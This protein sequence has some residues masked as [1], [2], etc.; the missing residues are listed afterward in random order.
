MHAG[1]LERVN[2]TGHRSTGVEA[3]TSGDRWDSEKGSETDGNR[4]GEDHGCVR[5]GWGGRNDK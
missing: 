2:A 4:F 1:G 3:A 5:V